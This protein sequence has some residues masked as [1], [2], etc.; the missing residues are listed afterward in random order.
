MTEVIALWKFLQ[1][2]G[3]VSMIGVL[4]AIFFIWKNDLKHL[5]E[6][7]KKVEAMILRHL[8]WHSERS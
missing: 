3:Q 2:L 8:A 7:L 1:E 4:V 6:G 5:A